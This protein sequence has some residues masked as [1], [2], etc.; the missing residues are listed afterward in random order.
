MKLVGLEQH[1]CLFIVEHLSVPSKCLCAKSYK[2]TIITE[3]NS[4]GSLL[5]IVFITRVEYFDTGLGARL[6]QTR[7]DAV[8]RGTSTKIDCH[9]VSELGVFH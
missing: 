2:L 4:G 6:D 7:C 5:V 8:A 1:C 9:Y 3:Q